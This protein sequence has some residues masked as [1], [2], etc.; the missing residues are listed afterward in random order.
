MIPGGLDAVQEDLANY[1]AITAPR[2]VWEDVVLN[3]VDHNTNM[4]LVRDRIGF[5]QTA[6]TYSCYPIYASIVQLVRAPACHAGS[7][8]FESRSRRQHCRF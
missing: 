6:D 5:A 3:G 8:G 7:H 2:M 1:M 4:G